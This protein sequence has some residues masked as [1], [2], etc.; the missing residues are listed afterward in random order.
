M[1][2][3]IGTFNFSTFS[4]IPEIE[5]LVNNFAD[6]T[7]DELKYSIFKN[8]IL[9]NDSITFTQSERVIIQSVIKQTTSFELEMPTEMALMLLSQ[10]LHVEMEEYLK[11]PL[12]DVDKRNK[13]GGGLLFDEY[14]ASYNDSKEGD[15][16]S[17]LITEYFTLKEE[18]NYYP[19][20][21]KLY[22]AKNSILKKFNQRLY[23]SK[24][25]SSFIG[26]IYEEFKQGLYTLCIKENYKLLTNENIEN[27]FK[28]VIDEYISQLLND[29]QLG[30]TMDDGKKAVAKLESSLESANF[31]SKI[32]D[33]YKV[34]F[35]RHFS[36]TLEFDF[37][38][39]SSEKLI[40]LIQD[41]LNAIGV[42]TEKLIVERFSDYKMFVLGEIF[43]SSNDV[44]GQIDRCI[45]KY[46]RVLKS[47]TV[48]KVLDDILSI[49]EFEIAI[50]VE[51]LAIDEKLYRKY[52]SEDVEVVSHTMFKSWQYEKYEELGLQKK[53]TFID[54][55]NK[56]KEESVWFVV[57]NILCGKKDTE[58]AYSIAKE[59]LTNYLEVLY[60]FVSSEDAYDYK[61]VDPY[62]L[63]NKTSGSIVLGRKES[64]YKS[65]K[66]VDD[67][68]HD[69]IMFLN[70]FLSSKKK[71]SVDINSCIRLY[72]KLINTEDIFSKSKLIVAIW[73]TIFNEVEGEKLAMSSAIVIAGT[74]YSS[75][76]VNITFKNMRG[77]L[78]WDFI[79]FINA[80]R[81][82]LY[83]LMIEEVLERFK[84]FTKNILGTYIFNIPW[85]DTKEY[86][87]G[88][89]LRWILYINPEEEYVNQRG[90]RN[91]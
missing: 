44:A 82:E 49:N 20:Y 50:R 17:L 87:D 12:T 45:E 91:D 84:V 65:V 31:K 61:I 35:E 47:E 78:Y 15:L 19:E 89:I 56:E 63:I 72:F 60:Y 32:I 53:P 10:I 13:K 11:V 37:Y 18:I 70:T 59:K 38:V 21:Y 75:N 9:V 39:S 4:F 5:S 68:T 62:V 26:K 57:R 29:Q 67:F 54:I 41:N 8:Y 6:A 83:P 1:Y 85:D 69:L 22:R 51:N 28:K 27:I 14:K 25:L 64:G 2:K 34:E 74:N 23:S 80:S 86:F 48:K 88:D 81:N 58:L 52:L 66:K 79:E 43:R 3:R 71:I 90:N 30:K 24:T 55:P 76:A 73:E 36:E 7:L 46:D 16:T 33:L 40:S 77:I 42:S